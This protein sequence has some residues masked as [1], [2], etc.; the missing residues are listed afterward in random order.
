[1]ALSE[2]VVPQNGGNIYGNIMINKWIMGHM[3]T[4]GTWDG[5]MMNRFF[6]GFFMFF[7]P[8]WTKP[9]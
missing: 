7:H 2:I 8:F 6:L 4:Y 9:Y 1:M 3:D 5:K